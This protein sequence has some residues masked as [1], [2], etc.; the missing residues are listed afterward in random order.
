VLNSLVS[1]TTTQGEDFS[2]LQEAYK[3]V[4]THRRNWFSAVAL[5]VGAW[6]RTARWAAAAIETFTRVPKES[7]R[8]R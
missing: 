2:L 1:A 8:R 4:L 5:N 7:S 3:A 6:S